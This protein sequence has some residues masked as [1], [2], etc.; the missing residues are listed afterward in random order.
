MRLSTLYQTLTTEQR[1]ILA[2]A[3]E[4]SPAY[5]YQLAT[6]WDGRKP[7]IPLMV[8]LANAD[9]RLS[10]ADLAEEFSE[11]PKPRGHAM[12]AGTEEQKAA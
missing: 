4:I 8:K 9:E 12:Q 7:S 2:K 11:A 1:E 5:L 10:L 3:A 6:R